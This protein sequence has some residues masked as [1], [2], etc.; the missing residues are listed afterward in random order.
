[1]FICYSRHELWSAGRNQNQQNSQLVGEIS[2]N[3]PVNVSSTPMSHETFFSLGSEPFVTN[4]KTPDP[5]KQLSRAPY[6]SAPSVYPWKK[7]PISKSVFKN[8]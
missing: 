7:A 2:L 3:W 1:M 4:N 5:P 8:S 6:G